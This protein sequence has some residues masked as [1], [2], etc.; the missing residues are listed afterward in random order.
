MLNKRIKKLY[1]TGGQY[2]GYKIEVPKSA[3]PTLSKVRQSVFNMLYSI[4]NDGKLFL[5]MFSGSGI[6]ALE[7][8]SRGYK[9]DAL[10]IEK[11]A[12]NQIKSAF[13]KLKL[14]PSVIL[15]DAMKYI[16]DKKYDIIYIDP[17]WKYDYKDIIIKANDLLSQKGLLIIEHDDISNDD[18]QNIIKNLNISINLVKSKK[19]G[20][21]LIDVYANY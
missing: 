11:N 1:L 7:A 19:Y 15:C 20:R 2:K 5:D 17:P 8:I 6:M 18:F 13:L 3:K 4:N 21:C 14:K 12:Y 9:A 16:T 10:E